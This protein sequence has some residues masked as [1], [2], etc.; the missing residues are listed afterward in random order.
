MSTQPIALVP[1]PWGEYLKPRRERLWLA[2]GKICY[3]CK[4]PTRLVDGD[5][6]DQATVDHVIPRYKGGD[7]GDENCVSACR[8]CNN[9][10]SHEDAKGLAE[11][12]L[13]GKYQV[14]NGK[15]IVGSVR[16]KIAAQQTKRYVAL[17]GDEKKALMVRIAST[18]KVTTVSAED[19]LREQRDQGLKK[20]AELQKEVSYWKTKAHDLESLTTMQFIR[21]KLAIWLANPNREKE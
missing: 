11:G 15:R 6:W 18:G 16:T 13:L 7:P 10:R 21:N 20:I 3:W 4:C 19:V 12:S 1:K 5:P 14:G 17:S 8:L 2:E 9:R